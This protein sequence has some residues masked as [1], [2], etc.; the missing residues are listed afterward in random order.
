MLT[1]VVTTLVALIEFHKLVYIMNPVVTLVLVWVINH[2]QARSLHWH[3]TYQLYH[4]P[5]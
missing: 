4:V 2:P 3:G 1:N 5:S